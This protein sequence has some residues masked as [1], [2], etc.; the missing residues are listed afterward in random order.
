[1]FNDFV[2]LYLILKY[3]ALRLNSI[4]FSNFLKYTLLNHIIW[5]DIERERNIGFNSNKF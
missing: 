3:K 1:M 2:K 5:N 4:C